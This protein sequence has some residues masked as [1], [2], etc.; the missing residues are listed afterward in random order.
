MTD[1]DEAEF[2]AVAEANADEID[3]TNPLKYCFLV[4]DCELF[5]TA[6]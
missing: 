2:I 4:G 6:H 3:T 5:F 1:K